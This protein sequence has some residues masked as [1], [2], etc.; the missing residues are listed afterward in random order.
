M[1]LQLTGGYGKSRV[2]LDTRDDLNEN[3]QYVPGDTP[4]WQ[5]ACPV[6]V[7]DGVIS[8]AEYLSWFQP[9]FF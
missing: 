4:G 9:G 2:P 8:C 5:G 6:D 3:S 1:G 7:V